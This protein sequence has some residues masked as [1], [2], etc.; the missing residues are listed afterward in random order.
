MEDLG[1]STFFDQS[2]IKVIRQLILGEKPSSLSGK[3]T[4]LVSKK[5]EIISINDQMNKGLI[6][7]LEQFKRSAP[8]YDAMMFL[9]RGLKGD[10]LDETV[11]FMEL[12][13]EESLSFASLD[14][15][16]V[17]EKLKETPADWLIHVYT[18]G[19][20]NRYKPQS[21]KEKSSLNMDA[22]RDFK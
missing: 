5:N 21:Y 4:V 20:E 2:S 14:I 22:L 19:E 10:M 17:L 16:E 9:I 18:E 6:Y 15:E 12:C 1:N 7:K 13:V 11:R 8:V 3:D